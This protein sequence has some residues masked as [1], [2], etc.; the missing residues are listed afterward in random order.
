MPINKNPA[1]TNR[2]IC[3]STLNTINTT[4]T[5]VTAAPRAA[6]FRGLYLSINSPQNGLLRKAGTEAMEI[7]EEAT[8]RE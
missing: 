5:P 8:K 4:E 6:S 7:M 1:Y 3:L 2:S